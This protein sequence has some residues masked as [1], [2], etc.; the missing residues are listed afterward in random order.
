MEEETRMAEVLQTQFLT[1]EEVADRLRVTRR[2]VYR[3]LTS[4]DLAGQRAGRGWRISER[5]LA[6][7]LNAQ[8][9]TAPAGGE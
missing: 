9:R 6:E 1:P 8:G 7:F 4:G 2:T 3:W 5:A